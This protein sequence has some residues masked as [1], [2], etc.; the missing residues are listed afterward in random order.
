MG[1]GPK[2]QTLEAKQGPTM[3]SNNF[4]FR[5]EELLDS[6]DLPRNTQ[7][8]K[9]QKS[10]QKNSSQSPTKQPQPPTNNGLMDLDINA[11][12]N[13]TNAALQDFHALQSA[14]TKIKS[15]DEKKAEDLR[16]QDEKMQAREIVEASIQAWAY[17]KMNPKQ[18][19]GIRILLSTMENIVW[20]SSNWEPVNI[21]FLLVKE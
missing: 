1:D 16:I 12:D 2:G 18:M 7:V 17:P 13:C 20:E 8:S 4:E 5:G 21:L 15:L 14:E 3:P 10:A 19:N 11:F 9:T 6:E